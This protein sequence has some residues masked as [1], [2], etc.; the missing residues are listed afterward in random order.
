MKQEWYG[1][2]WLGMG[3]LPESVLQACVP[4]NPC[5][6]KFLN[7]VIISMFFNLWRCDY[8]GLFFFC[9][10]SGKCWSLISPSKVCPTESQR[11]PT[12]PC[13]PDDVDCFSSN[14]PL[15]VPMPHSPHTSLTSPYNWRFSHCFSGAVTGLL[16]ECLWY[17]WEP[18]LFLYSTQQ[19]QKERLQRSKLH[20]QLNMANT[21]WLKDHTV[22]YTQR[23]SSAAITHYCLPNTSNECVWCSM[24]TIE[25]NIFIS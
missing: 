14:I 3:I 12:S 7:H 20:T 4:E 11:T 17:H 10:P 19:W 13:L 21:H 9:N 23:H 2:A 15:Q 22:W 18:W 6:E 8:L 5:P 24:L 16:L 25:K 1:N